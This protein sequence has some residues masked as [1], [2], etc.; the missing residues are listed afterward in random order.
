M[1]D[2]SGFWMT[3][4]VLFRPKITVRERH[5]YEACSALVAPLEQLDSPPFRHNLLIYL[6]RRV[7][8][9]T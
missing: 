6:S 5:E 9:T 3:H 1:P 2:L 7:C 4:D 8:L